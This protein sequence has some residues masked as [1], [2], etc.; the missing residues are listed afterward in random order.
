MDVKQIQ[1]KTALSPS[2]LPGLS[3]SLNPYR[4]CQHHCVY[5]Y[6]PNVLR[7]AQDQWD[8][9]VE[10]KANIPSILANEL[11]RKKT[12]VV[13]I[14]T[15]TDPYQPLEEKY[16]LTRFCLEQLLK[17][18]FPIHI[19]TKSNLVKRDIDLISRFSESQVMMSIATIHE[20]QR[21]V[22]EPYSSSILERLDVLRTY[23]DIGVKTS[24][25]FGP[26]YPTTSKE[27]IPQIL[28]TFRGAGATEIWIDLLRLKSGIWENIKNTLKQN[29]EIFRVFSKNV[30]EDKDYY[31]N[32]REE[33]HKKGREYNLKIIDAF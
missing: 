3:Y 25:F 6:A 21:K 14:S 12:G 13:G 24:V 32:I 11:K 18:D 23:A 31:R 8:T 17:V 9:I 2:S 5:C 30:L 27:E 19:Q 16:H 28:D 26:V 10:V 33:I 22:I 7:M 4:G 15:V 20:D 1:C 29:Q